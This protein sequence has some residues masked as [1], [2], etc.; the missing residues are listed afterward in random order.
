MSLGGPWE[1]ED[2]TLD[3][4]SQLFCSPPPTHPPTYTWW[5]VL[6]SPW[7]EA[8]IMSH[9]LVPRKNHCLSPLHSLESG[10]APFHL[11]QARHPLPW[12]GEDRP[13]GLSG[14]A[15]TPSLQRASTSDGWTITYWLTEPVVQ[16]FEKVPALKAGLTWRRN[17]MWCSS[18]PASPFFFFKSKCTTICTKHL[19]NTGRG[20]QTFKK[21]KKPSTQLGRTKGK[22][23]EER[24]SEKR[25]QDRTST[26]E[27][28]L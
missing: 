26:P 27:R 7:S 21:G 24:E 11:C 23:K 25:N 20:P 10:S 18:F 5:L 8:S 28:E 3:W 1:L 12:W 15:S 19:L 14:H 16:S 22:Q 4:A 17:R 6:F 9:P 13:S 2:L